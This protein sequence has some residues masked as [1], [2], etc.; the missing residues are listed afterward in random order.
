MGCAAEG[1]TKFI[2][3]KGRGHQPGGGGSKIFA[4]QNRQRQRMIDAGFAWMEA[5]TIKLSAIK[6]HSGVCVFQQLSQTV[7]LDFAL[8]SFGHSFEF[9]NLAQA[10]R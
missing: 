6:R 3:R 2:G 10:A 5:G 8:L 7:L 9:F 4:S 1:D